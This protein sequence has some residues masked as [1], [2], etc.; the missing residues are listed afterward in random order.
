MRNGAGNRGTELRLSSL[1]SGVSLTHASAGLIA[2]ECQR[3]TVRAG[4]LTRLA[5]YSR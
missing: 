3:M 1:P 4:G 2:C 5:R